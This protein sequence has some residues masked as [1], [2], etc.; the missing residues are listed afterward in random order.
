MLHQLLE[1][2]KLCSGGDV[3]ASIV[4]FANFIVLD[5]V[6]FDIVPVL[7]GERVGPWTKRE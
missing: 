2:L 5:V 4:Q 3:V 6:S 7:N 1:G